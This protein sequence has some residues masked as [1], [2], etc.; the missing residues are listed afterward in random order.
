MRIGQRGHGSLLVREILGITGMTVSGCGEPENGARFEI[1]VP[2]GSYRFTW[3][4]SHSCH[5]WM[6]K[7][8]YR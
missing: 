2:R 7:H 4:V 5:F 3:I 6:N 8:R 1:K